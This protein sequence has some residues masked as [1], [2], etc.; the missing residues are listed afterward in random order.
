MVSLKE[1]SKEYP[2]VISNN[3]LTMVQAHLD[4]TAMQGEPPYV[5]GLKQIF[6]S[7]FDI[8]VRCGLKAPFECSVTVE[9]RTH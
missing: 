7:A 5:Y 9:R 8:E 2:G 3:M 4:T 6:Y 1:F